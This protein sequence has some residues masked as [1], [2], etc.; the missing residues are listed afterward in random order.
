M[1]LLRLVTVAG[2]LTAARSRAATRDAGKATIEAAALRGIARD[3]VSSKR[4]ESF[5]F[6]SWFLRVLLVIEGVHLN[7]WRG[8]VRSVDVSR[9]SLTGKVSASITMPSAVVTKI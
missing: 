5:N 8:E 6:S 2:T 3:A 1:A 7:A 4:L 9:R